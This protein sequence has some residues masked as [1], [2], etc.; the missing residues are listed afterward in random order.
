VL[1]HFVGSETF[2]PT[3]KF[4][5]ELQ[6]ALGKKVLGI[7]KRIVSNKIESEINVLRWNT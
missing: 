1:P 3:E 7:V 2:L 6:S 4:V 5:E